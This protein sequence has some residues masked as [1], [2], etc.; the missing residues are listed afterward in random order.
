MFGVPQVQHEELAWR[1]GTVVGRICLDHPV[2]SLEIRAQP[3]HAPW[4]PAETHKCE[5]LDHLWDVEASFDNRRCCL[6]LAAEVDGVGVTIMNGMGAWE[7]ECGGAVDSRSH[8]DVTLYDI[9]NGESDHAAIGD[10]SQERIDIVRRCLTMLESN[11]RRKERPNIETIFKALSRTFR[12]CDID[13]L[14]DLLQPASSHVKQIAASCGLPVA[15]FRRADESLTASP[16]TGQE[17]AVLAQF[18]LFDT[19]P[20]TTENE[21][22]LAPII[23][24]FESLPDPLVCAYARLFRHLRMCSAETMERLSNMFEGRLIAEALLEVNGSG[25]L[26]R[27]VG[28]ES[29]APSF[30]SVVVRRIWGLATMSRRARHLAPEAQLPLAA[31]IA[32]SLMDSDVVGELLQ[33]ALARVELDLFSVSAGVPT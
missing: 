24:S 13:I 1:T 4:L 23:E 33:L 16:H 19:A 9:L 21:T 6:S 31:S 8:L 10:N 12:V 5:G 11:A 14:D 15:A 22:S 2:D 30:F 32:S 3:F 20:R 17:P 7:K 29:G 18:I 25:Y 28:R 27:W 26:E